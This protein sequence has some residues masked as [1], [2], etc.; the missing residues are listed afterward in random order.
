[1]KVFTNLQLMTE[2]LSCEAHSGLSGAH[3]FCM[4]TLELKQEVSAKKI[5]GTEDGLSC[6]N[7]VEMIEGFRKLNDY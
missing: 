6:H 1:V 5:A 7:I 3:F 2:L 4:I